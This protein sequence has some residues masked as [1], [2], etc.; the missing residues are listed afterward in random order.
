M[1][2]M[3]GRFLTTPRLAR[4]PVLVQRAGLAWLFGPR[5]LLLEHT[6]RRSRAP[7]FTTLEV[8][9]DQRP[10]ALIVAS[11]FG[12]RAQWYRNLRA[13]PQCHVWHQFARRVPATA[14]L[15][16]QQAGAAVLARYQRAHPRL[17]ARLRPVISEATG[18]A[19]PQ[20]PVVRLRLGG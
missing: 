14:E 20:I 10:Q 15:L 1:A 5:L 2:G 16:D 6:G 11:G 12:E 19:D 3:L 8:V 18:Q 9:E 13:H 17:W 7:R 4:A